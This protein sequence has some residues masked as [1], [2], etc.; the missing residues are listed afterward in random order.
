VRGVRRRCL[1]LA[2]VLG[3][4]VCG[5]AATGWTLGPAKP[6]TARGAGC[7]MESGRE[8]VFDG[9]QETWAQIVVDASTVRVTS[10]SVLDPGDRD[11]GLSVDGGA[12]VVA[13]EV[14]GGRTAVFKARYGPLVEDFRRGLRVRAQLRFWPTW[15]KTGTHDVTFG[16]IGFTRAHTGMGECRAP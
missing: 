8:P 12:L 13:D 7:V 5:L 15:P 14:V 10:G 11:I 1:V 3:L 2:V 9:Y 6:A 4:P 16:L